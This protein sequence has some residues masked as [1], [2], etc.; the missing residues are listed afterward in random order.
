MLLLSILLVG[1]KKLPSSPKSRMEKELCLLLGVSLP[2]RISRMLLPM[3]LTQPQVINGMSMIGFICMSMMHCFLSELNY[4]LRGGGGIG[5]FLPT[6]TAVP[7]NRQG[8][9][10]R[11]IYDLSFFLLIITILLNIIF[12]IIIDT[13]AQLRDDKCQTDNDMRDYCFICNL[14]KQTFDRET[15]DGFV[16]HRT[17]DHNEWQYVNF[18]IH[19]K[20]IDPCDLNGTES[21]IL[22]LFE[23]EEIKW[24][25][26]ARS[27]R[28]EQ[29][30]A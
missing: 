9:Y 29:L 10:F 25:P 13:F 5:D 11:A 27:R 17:H 26:M 8:F 23:K 30:Y 16:A 14:E 2:M 20:S 24:F 15:E 6:Q 1:S 22:E 7:E 28:L 4:G 21:Y 18:I 12:G 19:I 3:F